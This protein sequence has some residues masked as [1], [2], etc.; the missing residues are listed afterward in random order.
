MKDINMFNNDL[1]KEWWYYTI[2]KP[3]G[4]FYKGIYRDDMVLLPRKNL[5]KINLKGKSALDI[6]TMEGLMPTIMR[7]SG[8]S[9]VFATDSARPGDYPEDG[10]D[11]IKSNLAKMDEIKR[12]H[13]VE[14]DYSIV[15]EKTTVFEHM[16][17]RGFDQFDLINLSGLLYHVYSPMHWIG[18]VRPLVKNGGLAIIST[19]VTFDEKQIML[20][21]D[22]GCLQNNLTTYWYLSVPLFDYMLRYFRLRP[23]R[24]EYSVYEDGHG[25]MSV[26]C[27][28]EPNVIADSSDQ[29]MES[30]AWHSW[31]S[32]WFGGLE[33]VHR[34]QKSDIAFKDGMELGSE[35]AA[36]SSAP[37]LKRLFNVSSQTVPQDRLSLL[38]FVRNTKPTPFYGESKYTAVLKLND[39][40]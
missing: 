19:N 14:F 28:A 32:K 29:W 10:N 37:L 3:E 13:N 4:D 18:S 8:A 25:Y 36:S 11:T 5:A 39:Y 38:D 24:A 1:E 15:P 30:S 27:R 9:E 34:A 23:I 12:I 40:E 17:Q 2:Q 31:D 21:N 20:F 16:H 26:V 35:V 7:K 33:M 6:C 22:K